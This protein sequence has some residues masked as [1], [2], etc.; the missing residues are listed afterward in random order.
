[1]I[2]R[3]VRTVRSFCRVCTSVCGIL[4]DVAGDAVV[5]VR[6]DPDHPLSHGYTCAKGRAL[7]EL[8]HH[9]ER[10]QQLLTGALGADPQTVMPALLKTLE[11]QINER[12]RAGTM[13]P[14]KPEQFVINLISLCVF[15]FA[16]RPMLSIVFGMDD[17]AFKRFIE[18]RKKDLPAFFR[19]ALRP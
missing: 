3:D 12:V 4:V 17:V 6:G 13:R 1:M 7:P 8:H 19:S 5:R 10:V 16:A 15:P 9:P 14:I 18:Q 2:E 11:R